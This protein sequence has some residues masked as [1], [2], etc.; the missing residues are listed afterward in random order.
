MNHTRNRFNELLMDDVKSERT[1]DT[2]ERYQRKSNLSACLI[3]DLWTMHSM[4]WRARQIH[5]HCTYNK[6]FSSSS[7][8]FDE[9]IEFIAVNCSSTA[10][11]SMT[12]NRTYALV[13]IELTMMSCKV[14]KCSNFLSLSLIFP[15]CWPFCAMMRSCTRTNEWEMIAKEDEWNDTWT[16]FH[17]IIDVSRSK[18]RSNSNNVVFMWV[19]NFSFHCLFI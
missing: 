8:V 6:L 13:I 18:L 19:V 9:W 14:S 1:F 15:I 4:H 2:K 10:P 17:S 12:W 5:F 7:L 11:L 3:D 16:C